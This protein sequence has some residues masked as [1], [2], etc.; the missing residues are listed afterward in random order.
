MKFYDNTLREGCQSALVCMSSSQRL[1]V[2]DS[3]I[4]A[5]IQQIEIGFIAAG[6]NEEKTIKYSLQRKKYAKLYCLARLLKDDINKCLDLGCENVTIFV[7]SSDNLLK[8]KLNKNITEIE[9]DIAYLVHYANQNGLS[10]RFSCEDATRTPL[11]RL[12]KFYSLAIKSGAHTI[13]VPDTFG[14]ATPQSY[15]KLIKF[16]SKN[17]KCNISAHCHNDLGLALANSLSC[18]ENNGN[19]IQTTIYGLGDRVGNTDL[20][21]VIIALKRF[22]NEES[23]KTISKIKTLYDKFSNITGFIPPINFPIISE[24]QFSHESGLHVKALINNNPYEAFPPKWIDAEHKVLYGELS[25]KAN[26]E[27]FCKKNC[28]SLNSLEIT[29]VLKCIKTFSSEKKRYL[30][31]YEVNEIIKEIKNHDNK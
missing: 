19:E 15:G 5:G 29:E 23:I 6:Q 16:L 27:Y 18:Y 7:P 24:N 25:G 9:N 13:S 2:L 28:I 8:T 21:Q 12:L 14:I 17:L 10:V 22:Y 30:S 4:E 31:E 20:I 3:Q 11:K 1:N 26:I